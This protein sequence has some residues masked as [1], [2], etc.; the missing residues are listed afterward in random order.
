MNGPVYID[1]FSPNLT[2]NQNRTFQFS[3]I[4]LFMKNH[5]N[6][7]SAVRNFHS[8]YNQGTYLMQGS[9]QNLP[10]W[11]N[12]SC[13]GAKSKGC[14][15]HQHNGLKIRKKCILRKQPL[16]H[17]LFIICTLLYSLTID[18]FLMHPIAPVSHFALHLYQKLLYSW[19]IK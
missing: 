2:S 12:H 19:A 4:F 14:P 5:H 1:V 16:V 9:V 10:K 17:T 7:T 15:D 18:Q 3:L 8:N 6:T 13:V 11:M